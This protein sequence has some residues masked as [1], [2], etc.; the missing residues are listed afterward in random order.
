M[1]SSGDIQLPDM[2]VP[3]NLEFYRH[4]IDFENDTGRHELILG[5]LDRSQQR[6]VQ[7]IAHHRNCDYEYQ[8]GYARVLRSSTTN[9]NIEAM[10][11]NSPAEITH[12]DK[13]IDSGKLLDESFPFEMDLL[14][15]NLEVEPWL[16]DSMYPYLPELPSQLAQNDVASEGLPL[17]QPEIGSQLDMPGD[18]IYGNPPA[19]NGK[20]LIAIHVFEEQ[21]LPNFASGSGS[22]SVSSLRSEH[23]CNRIT[24]ISKNSSLS[25][26]NSSTSQ[27]MDATYGSPSRY[28]SSRGSGRSGPLTSFARTGMKA[29][30]MIGGAC[31]RCRIL[32]KKRR[33]PAIL[34]QNESKLAKLL[35]LEL[36]VDE[37]HFHNRWNLSI[38][39]RNQFTNQRL[40]ILIFCVFIVGVIGARAQISVKANVQ[41]AKKSM[42]RL[43]DLSHRISKLSTWKKPQ[44]DD[45]R[46]YYDPHQ[47]IAQSLLCLREALE[48]K[49]VKTLGALH[50]FFH[51]RCRI[52][53]DVDLTDLVIDNFPAVKRSEDII[54]LMLDTGF[55]VPCAF[56]YQFDNG[57]FRGKAFAEFVNNREARQVI[58]ALHNFKIDYQALKVEFK[59]YISRPGERGS[60]LSFCNDKNVDSLMSAIERLD[61]QSLVQAI[62]KAIIG[63]DG[64]EIPSSINQYLHLAVRLFVATSGAHDPLVHGIP[65][66][67]D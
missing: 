33:I 38:Y 23:G 29:I 47:L 22:G 7:S 44:E 67:D 34:V 26:C 13:P 37:A 40:L 31:W 51:E 39:V 17:S 63:D 4:I 18:D 48:L 45:K 35:G 57:V 55:P 19:L 54:K 52:F 2:N 60:S 32:G 65:V 16:Q 11:E 61:I 24:Q 56:N 30:K 59:N 9:G 25:G 12:Y 64:A 27:T 36:A 3:S 28:A 8:Q 5:N 21:G 6:A 62:L 58:D 46:M 49:R 1:E 20:R 41:D 66:Q 10:I 14:D 42:Q 50:K 43:L 15:S 53:E